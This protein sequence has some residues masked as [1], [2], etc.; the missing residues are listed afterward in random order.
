M[1]WLR[2]P[3][4]IV[5]VIGVAGLIVL[6]T[7]GNYRFALVSPGGND[8]M[9]HYSVW[10]AF[11][12]R[13]L[14]P[15][16][17]EAALYTQLRIYGRPASSTEDQNRLTYPFYS[18]V[19]NGPFS[20][21]ADYPLAR[22][23]Y[24][25]FLEVALILGLWLTMRVVAWRPPFWL[26]AVLLLWVLLDYP[27]ARGI[28]LGQFAIFGF[29]SLVTTMYLLQ[30]G[31]DGWA[32]AV[33]VLSTMKPTLV[34]LV[35]PFLLLWTLL[36]RRWRFA[37]GFGSTLAGS[38]LLSWLLLPTWLTDWLYRVSRYSEYTVGQSPVW[39]FTHLGWPTLG[40]TGEVVLTVLLL[41]LML[42]AWWQSFKTMAED[43]LLWTLGVTLVVS[44]L[45]ISR[46]ATTNY[47]LLL[48]PTL[49]LFAQVTR[50][51]WGHAAIVVYMLFMLVGEW[52]L[53]AITVV[54]NQEQPIMFLPLPLVLG[55]ALVVAR[56]RPGSP[57]R[58]QVAR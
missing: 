18:I 35:V 37:L 43:C 53:H 29:L 54:G 27:Q 28:I 20:L 10:Q 22:A 52:W 16:S 48:L 41:G 24:M 5:T 56:L 40:Q 4:S 12:E 21:I 31:H 11:F 8:F 39:L 14:N 51:R 1:S 47:V 38:M 50:W 7:L 55:C 36:R 46:S 32:G 34:F 23:I 44:D 33:L 26:L 42:L 17:D 19:L 57:L 6:L 25:V 9:A 13:G 3:K 49:W 30:R 45:I 2:K 58:L 15:Y